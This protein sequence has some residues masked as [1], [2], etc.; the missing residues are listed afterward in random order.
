MSDFDRQVR[1]IAEPKVMAALDRAKAAYMAEFGDFV[2]GIHKAELAEHFQKAGEC[3]LKALLES[4]KTVAAQYAKAA[5]RHMDSIETLGVGAVIIAKAK[6]ASVLRVT[7]GIILD[8]LGDVA[9]AVIKTVASGLLEGLLKGVMPE[10]GVA[11]EAG[12]FP[13]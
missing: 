7:A 2:E 1:E 4:D 8:T 5:E 3:K 9:L 10:G 13:G 6:T 12:N 11:G